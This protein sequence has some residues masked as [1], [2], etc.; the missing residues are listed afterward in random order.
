[1]FGIVSS[2]NFVPER[3]EVPAEL[4]II[5]R[6]R[7][8]D[9]G[10]GPETRRETL[11][12]PPGVTGKREIDQSLPE[13]VGG[14]GFRAGSMPPQPDWLHSLDIEYDASTFDSESARTTK[15]DGAGTIFP[16]RVDPSAGPGGIRRDAVYASA[17]L[18][19]VVILKQESIDI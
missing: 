11:P 2:F 4:R 13:G 10:P 12:R 8:R 1:M 15:P 18:H 9:R 14:D 6:A 7:V 3:Y 16:F 17:G 19:P 5:S